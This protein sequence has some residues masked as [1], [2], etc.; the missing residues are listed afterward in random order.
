MLQESPRRW[1]WWQHRSALS[2]TRVRWLGGQLV[3]PADL[4]ESE[5]PYH[6]PSTQEEG[7]G[8]ICQAARSA[9]R[10]GTRKQNKNK[11]VNYLWLFLNK[12]PNWLGRILHF[13][14]RK[15]EKKKKTTKPNP[16]DSFF[17]CVYFSLCL[18]SLVCHLPEAVTVS[19]KF[20]VFASAKRLATKVVLVV[21]AFFKVFFWGG[22]AGHERREASG[23]KMGERQQKRRRRNM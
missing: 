1:H 10:G 2:K 17:L 20:P 9:S 13:G 8:L 5:E 12:Y 4:G 6:Q 7:A 18:W 23:E 19:Q 3:A 16:T 14:G 11:K 22:E 15:E 21:G